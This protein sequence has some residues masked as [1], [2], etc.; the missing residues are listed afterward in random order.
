MSRRSSCHCIQ[1]VWYESMRGDVNHSCSP[2][3]TRVRAGA[4]AR[5]VRSEPGDRGA[6][7]TRD[8]ARAFVERTEPVDHRPV[9]R[10]VAVVVRSAA[11]LD[12]PVGAELQEL[13]VE[14]Q[15]PIERAPHPLLDLAA[16]LAA[17]PLACAARPRE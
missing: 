10:G 12:L 14:H 9:V 11:P 8:G 2:S 13:G 4:Q 16:R 17:G 1:T 6:G 7:V 3:S 5:A 15:E